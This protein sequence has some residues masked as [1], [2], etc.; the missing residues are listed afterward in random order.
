MSQERRSAKSRPPAANP[1]PAGNT[2]PQGGNIV[3]A[4]E[5]F[6]RLLSIAQTANNQAAAAI[7]NQP[8]AQAPADT[9]RVEPGIG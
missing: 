3:L 8:V 6:E 5:Q 9:V 1:V 7:G 4:P 2:S